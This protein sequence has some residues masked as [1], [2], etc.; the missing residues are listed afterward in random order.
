MSA[1]SA[2]ATTS[3]NPAAYSVEARPN[4]TVNCGTRPGSERQG[5]ALAHPF[6]HAD[7]HRG[8][9]VGQDDHE[10][11]PAEAGD[12]VVRPHR[13]AQYVRE[14]AQGLVAGLVTVRIVQSLE[15]VEVSVR[16][17]VGD[18]L[19]VE[20]AHPVFEA[21]PVQQAGER[22][23]ARLRLGGRERADHR[24]AIGSSTRG[25]LQ[26]LDR[27]VG[28]QDAVGPD[29]V[30]DADRVPADAHRQARGRARPRRAVLEIGAGI[31]CAAAREAE[32]LAADRGRAVE[33]RDDTA[34]VEVGLVGE[35]AAE[36]RAARVGDEHL[37]LQV[38]QLLVQGLA[39]DAVDVGLGP[40]HLERLLQAAFVR[41]PERFLPAG[42]RLASGAAAEDG[43][44][45]HHQ[46]E[47]GAGHQ[48][49]QQSSEVEMIGGLLDLRSDDS[50]GKVS[51]D[52]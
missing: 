9:A 12:D 13:V 50:L 7:G 14:R 36:M 5:Q 43:G 31:E 30:G 8:L 21:A 2:Q 25:E 19:A 11:L 48:E 33:R 27:F 23:G 52:P 6:E 39:E 40:S 16:E 51:A 38:R 37:D 44:A 1:P 28:R 24:D 34:S 22:V 49:E 41:V 46:H 35:R 26:R 18:S 3:S 47:V 17:R 29:G 10:L 32:G 42:T 45:D 4:V 20:V 15:V